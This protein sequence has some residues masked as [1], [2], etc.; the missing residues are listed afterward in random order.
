[1][2]NLQLTAETNSSGTCYLF[3]NFSFSHLSYS[4]INLLNY[5]K[6][7]QFGRLSKVVFVKWR[8]CILRQKLTV[9]ERVIFLKI[10][11]FPI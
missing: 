10:L 3:E 6:K 2:A 9:V 7:Y 4:E 11:V 5:N 8:I 1:M